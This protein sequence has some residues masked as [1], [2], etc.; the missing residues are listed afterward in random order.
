MPLGFIHLIREETATGTG[1][2]YFCDLETAIA[3]INPA[4]LEGFPRDMICPPC[5]KAYEDGEQ[6]SGHATS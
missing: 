2:V 1:A 3:A 4:R 6:A 5:L